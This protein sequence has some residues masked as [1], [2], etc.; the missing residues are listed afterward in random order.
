LLL[1]KVFCS[2]FKS[3]K[4]VHFFKPAARFFRKNHIDTDGF[5]AKP[6]SQVANLKS[7]KPSPKTALAKRVFPDSFSAVAR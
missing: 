6:S 3:G 7:E 4:H 1:L 2:N 5:K